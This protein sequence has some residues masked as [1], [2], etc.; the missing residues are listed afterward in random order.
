MPLRIRLQGVPQTIQ[1][2]ERAAEE[3]YFDATSLISGG[4]LAPGIY[5]AGYTAEML[6]KCAY[7]LLDG[8]LSDESVLPRL[9]PSAKTGRII[10][11]AVA[12]EH[13]HSLR[14]WAGMIRLRR[15]RNGR[16]LPYLLDQ[17]LVQRT[18]RLYQNWWVQ[19]RYLKG[20]TSESE[21]RIVLDDVSWIRH[22]YRSLWR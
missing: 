15:Q 18:R 14:F 5:L 12:F 17:Q 16:G 2:M 10:L 11:P 19:M 13:G 21:V 22:H 3:R 9:G 1:E 7:F 4:R 20:R 6:L 8:A